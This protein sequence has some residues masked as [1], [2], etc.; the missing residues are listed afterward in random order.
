MNVHILL[1]EDDE[2]LHRGIQF[3]LQQEGFTVFSA[4]NRME[5]ANLIE[6]LREEA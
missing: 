5:K 2:S 3:T 6:E 4:Y 1:V